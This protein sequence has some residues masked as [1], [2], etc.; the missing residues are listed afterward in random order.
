MARALL[1]RRVTFAAAH[2]YRRPEW[3]DARNAATFGLCA[4]PNY[5][6]HSYVCDITVVGT[7][8]PLTGFVVDLGRLDAV[9]LTEVRERFDHRNINLDV[10]EFAEGALIPT[11]ENLAKN[12]FERVQSALGGAALVMEVKLAED[13]NLSVTYRG[14]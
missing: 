3:D 13:E 12:I 9:L 8:D 10:A 2:R 14:A 1:T 6:G 11:G 7:I 5:H 4:R